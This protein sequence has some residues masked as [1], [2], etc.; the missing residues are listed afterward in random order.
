MLDSGDGLAVEPGP[1][2]VLGRVGVWEGGV[3][4]LV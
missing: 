4:S 3:G 2:A 1:V